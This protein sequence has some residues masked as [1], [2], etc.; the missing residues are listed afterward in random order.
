MQAAVTS[1]RNDMAAC[2][3]QMQQARVKSKRS[4]QGLEWSSDPGPFA[5]WNLTVGE[6]MNSSILL[7]LPHGPSAL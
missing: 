1:L 2:G 3:D 5:R 4:L 7:S 6:R